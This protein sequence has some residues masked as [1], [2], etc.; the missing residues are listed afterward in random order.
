MAATRSRPS[1]LTRLR[2]RRAVERPQDGV[3]VLV[4]GGL[5]ECLH[6]DHSLDRVAVAPECGHVGTFD[7]R[8][9][10]QTHL[11]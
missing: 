10:E 7:V 1:T 11:R 2:L 4:G 5:A 6:V 8:V 3:V 9:R